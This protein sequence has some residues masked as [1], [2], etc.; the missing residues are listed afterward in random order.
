MK[1]SDTD[2]INFIASACY[3]GGRSPTWLIQG[4]EAGTLR[5]VVDAA[6]HEKWEEEE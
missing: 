2:R 6:I 5:E 1:I 3:C 4:E